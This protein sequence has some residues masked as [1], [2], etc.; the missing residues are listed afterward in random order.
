MADIAEL[1]VR[2]DSDQAQNSIEELLRRMRRLQRGQDDIRRNQDDL[3]DSTNRLANG[4]RLMGTA[5]AGL[6]AG[7]AVNW[8]IDTARASEQLNAQ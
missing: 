1:E 4:F 2:I 6:A 5:L 7:A 8:F 3:N